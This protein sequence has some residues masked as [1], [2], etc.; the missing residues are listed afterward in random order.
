VI[1]VH[2][3][4]AAELRRP[5]L[6]VKAGHDLHYI[7]SLRNVSRH[8]FRFGDCPVFEQSADFGDDPVDVRKDVVVLNCRGLKPLQP[9]ERALFDVVLRVPPDAKRGTHSVGWTLEPR[10]YLPPFDAAEFVVSD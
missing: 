9:R 5:F 10:T 1:L 2:G 6:H 3:R 8:S 4:P 7:V